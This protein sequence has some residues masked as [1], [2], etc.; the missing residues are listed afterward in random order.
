MHCHWRA[1]CLGDSRQLYNSGNWQYTAHTHQ[2]TDKTLL[3]ISEEKLLQPTKR[4]W[5]GLAVAEA[6]AETAAAAAAVAV[7]DVAALGV[8]IVFPK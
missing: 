5:E 3:P 1:T 7:G 6:E 4:W 2:N 8:G